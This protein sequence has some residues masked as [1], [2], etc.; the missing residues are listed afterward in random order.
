M[1][2][3]AVHASF[4]RDVFSSL[5]P[6]IQSVIHSDS[7]TI[8]LFGPDLWFLYKPWRRREGRGRQMHTTRP[9]AFLTALLERAKV[10]PRRE[11]LFSWLA[12][13]FCHYALDS[14]THPYI[15]YITTEEY[16]YPRCHMNFEHE[17]DMRQIRRDGV[18]DTHHPVTDH[19]FPRV[20][21]PSS[22]KNDVDAVF[23]QVYGWKGGWKAF[24]RSARRYR[25]CYKLLEN[26]SGIVA[27]LARL[28]KR[29][30]LRS[31][32]YSE[33]HFRDIDVENTEHRP[34]RH[35]HDA[36]LTF[37]DSFPDLREKA[38]VQAVNLIESSF[39]YLWQSQ[40]TAEELSALIGNNSYLSGLPTDDPRNHNVKSLLPSSSAKQK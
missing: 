40:G 1:P 23:E 2:D 12:G 18:R 6:E 10:S 35:S 20:S 3:V 22:V 39:R 4:G 33:S 13:L 31:F 17:L 36:S 32:S 15:I 14:I 24:N 16:H 19:Y 30:L 21:L 27:R 5:S 38:R 26:P 25:S 29:P 34:W 9:G 28:T 11:E 37:A 7:W 8:G